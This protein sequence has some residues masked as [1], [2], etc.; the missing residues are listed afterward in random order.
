MNIWEINFEKMQ[1]KKLKTDNGQEYIVKDKGLF[2]VKGNKQIT[3]TYEL[4]DIVKMNFEEVSTRLSGWERRNTGDIYYTIYRELISAGQD[5]RD[6]ISESSYNGCN[7]FSTVEKAEE[8][9]KEQLLYRMMKK[10]RDE[11]DKCI[12]WNNLI[13]KSYYIY[14]DAFI[15]CY[16]IQYTASIR[17]LHTI[18][19]T[20]KELAERCLDEIVK[21]FI[22]SNKSP[23]L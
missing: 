10:F 11:N 3:A 17:N 5:F 22:K 18:Y 9:L 4:E 13:Q 1:G 19:F 16:A 15:G 8:V 14:Y 7:Y 21:P 6:H 20:T 2:S 23:I 12:D